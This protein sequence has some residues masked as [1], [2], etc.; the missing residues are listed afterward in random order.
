MLNSSFSQH[1]HLRCEVMSVTIRRA[2]NHF[3]HQ[4]FATLLKKE[5]QSIS[6]EE[7]S[8]ADRIQTARQ[9]QWNWEGHV[10]CMSQE[11]LSM[12]VIQRCGGIQ[13]SV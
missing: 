4:C 2:L 3:C 5:V 13:W 7:C 1:T 10:E 12:H 11:R 6:A 9:L 8:M